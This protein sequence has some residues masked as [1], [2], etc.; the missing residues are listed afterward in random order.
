MHLAV[1][2]Y[3]ALNFALRYVKLGYVG[4]PVSRSTVV[5]FDERQKSKEVE[6]CNPENKQQRR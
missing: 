2:W 1:S 5:P 4:C 3:S 6:K